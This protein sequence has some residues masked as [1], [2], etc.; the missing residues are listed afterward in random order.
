MIIAHLQE[1]IL[2]SLKIIQYKINLFLPSCSPHAPSDARHF[3]R[4]S[5][6]TWLDRDGAL[7]YYSYGHNNRQGAGGR[8]EGSRP[9]PSSR[10]D[11]IDTTV[12]QVASLKGCGVLIG[13]LNA[14]GKRAWTVN[15]YRE[16]SMVTLARSRKGLGGEKQ[17]RKGKKVLARPLSPARKLQGENFPF[18]YSCFSCLS[19]WSMAIEK[20][21]FLVP[22]INAW[23]NFEGSQ[24]RTSWGCRILDNYILKAHLSMQ[25]CW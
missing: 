25:K 2:H 4:V 14:L 6:V 10:A 15:I 3:S 13:W 11:V 19:L 22:S 18:L 20:W 12:G 9:L 23:P 21:K 8:P 17:E 7:T 24:A 1:L 5:F 16:E